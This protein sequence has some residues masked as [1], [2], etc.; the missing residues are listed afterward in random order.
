MFLGGGNLLRLRSVLWMDGRRQSTAAR[1]SGGLPAPPVIGFVL[2][3]AAGLQYVQWDRQR[4][5]RAGWEH[6]RATLLA[7]IEEGEARLAACQSALRPNGTVLAR[8][9]Q[10]IE[11]NP[12][13][14]SK[15]S[16]SWTDIHKELKTV[17]AEVFSETFSP[18]QTQKDAV[19]PIVVPPAAE[20]T[21]D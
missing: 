5:E 16:L 8:F 13:V 2:L 17:I 1:P 14:K 4:R 18:P 20:T 6:E 19:G 9:S 21:A 12:V 10:R 11:S 15:R 3:G 7:R